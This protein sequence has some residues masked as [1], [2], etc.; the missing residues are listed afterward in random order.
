MIV[1][2]SKPRTGVYIGLKQPNKNWLYI[3]FVLLFVEPHLE[4]IAILLKGRS[5]DQGGGVQRDPSALYNMVSCS[6]LN[7]TPHIGYMKNNYFADLNTSHERAILNRH[8][9]KLQTILHF[10][11][12]FSSVEFGVTDHRLKS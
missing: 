7:P 8:R 12:Y 2:G 10:Y 1:D 4:V 11:Y 6:C 9:L 5:P 3:W